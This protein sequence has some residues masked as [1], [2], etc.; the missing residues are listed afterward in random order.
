MQIHDAVFVYRLSD[1]QLIRWHSRLHQHPYPQF[2]LHYFLGGD[3]HFEEG[4]VRYQLRHGMLFLTAPGLDHRVIPGSHATP[5]S[6]FALLFSARDEPEL[7]NLLKNG[8]V[9]SRFPRVRPT[10]ERLVF[11]DV[12]TRFAHPDPS[13]KQAG[14]CRLASYLWDLIAD[15][16]DQKPRPAT[17][18][19]NERYNVHI[20]RALQLMQA[21]PDRPLSVGAIARRIGVSQ[22]HL[23]RLFTRWLGISP[24]AYY[25]RLHMEVAASRL[26]NSTKSVKE[27]AWELGYAHPV[28]FSRR[29]RRYSGMSPMAYRTAYYTTAPTEYA[30]RLTET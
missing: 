19:Q 23:S 26:I 22:E 18:T 7:E 15:T 4:L 5:L 29:F 2:E 6:Y 24:G 3:G 10:T 1:P 9:M 21:H 27:I 8:D 28:H 30:G 11:E 20:D 17:A 14:R 13:R 25:Q 16:T 12:S